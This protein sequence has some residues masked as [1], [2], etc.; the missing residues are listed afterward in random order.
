M[1]H[2]EGACHLGPGN[3][4]SECMCEEIDP[5]DVLCIPC[6]GVRQSAKGCPACAR[7]WAERRGFADAILRD[8]FARAIFVSAWADACE[9][10]LGERDSAFE[11]YDCGRAAGKQ[12]KKRCK[13]AEIAR[14]GYAG[15]GQ[16]W[17]DTA[18]A[19]SEHALATAREALADIA[20]SNKVD[21]LDV[22]AANIELD[23][24]EGKP[25]LELF[26]H[27]LGMQWLGHGVAWSDS[28]PDHELELGYGEYHINDV[29]HPE[30]A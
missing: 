25:T 6:E 2:T 27:Y 1:K 26:G 13:A 4:W 7:L 17:M 3:S 22:F 29:R 12:H 16:D 30:E 23:G 21:L 14:N 5:E 24:H 28:H 19:T 11:C 10:V 18:P 15:S 20:K 9:E 8:G